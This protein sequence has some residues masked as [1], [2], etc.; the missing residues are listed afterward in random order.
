MIVA[1]NMS[2]EPRTLKLSQQELGG[3]GKRLR[4]AISNL[5][6]AAQQTVVGGEVTLA[7]YEAAVFAVTGK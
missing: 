1:L 3:A 2:N 6:R 7:P 4:V 5:T